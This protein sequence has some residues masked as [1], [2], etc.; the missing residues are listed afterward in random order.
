MIPLQNPFFY[1]PEDGNLL[2][3]VRIPECEYTAFFNGA[4]NFPAIVSSA[5]S[6]NV[7]S[8]TAS[9]IQGDGLVTPSSG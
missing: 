2:L 7:D 4:T 5:F 1:N 3:D 6:Q 9:N 8:P